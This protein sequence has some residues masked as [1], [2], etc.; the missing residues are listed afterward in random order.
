MTPY[1]I[2]AICLSSIAIL[3]P[4]IQ[5]AWKKWIKRPIINYYPSGKITLFFNQSGSYVRLDGAVEAINKSISIQKINMQIVRC[6]D[7]K[8]LNLTWSCFISP[9]TQNF[10]GVISHSTEAAHPFKIL[11]DQVSCVFTEFSDDTYG[12]GKRWAQN[13]KD[14]FA[15]MATLR[16]ECTNY[17][18]AVSKYKNYPEFNLAKQA[19]SRDFFWEIGK[20]KFNIEFCFLDKKVKFDYEFNINETEYIDLK[21]NIEESLICPLKDAYNIQRMFHS[22]SIEIRPSNNL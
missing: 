3:I 10:I 15:H 1:E 21:N 16:Q 9:I 19:I 13:T 6:S 4:I 14:L 11:E 2:V 18:D 12:A 5:W 7:D 20:Y 17:D 22:P 8:H